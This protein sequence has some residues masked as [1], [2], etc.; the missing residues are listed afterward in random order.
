MRA[1]LMLLGL[2]ATANFTRCS[3]PQSFWCATNK[4]M[5]W[6]FQQRFGVIAF[7][8]SRSLGAAAGRR[9]RL[10]QASVTSFPLP[11][12]IEPSSMRD[13]MREANGWGLAPTSFALEQPLTPEQ[14]SRQ[15]CRRALTFAAPDIAAWELACTNTHN[16]LSRDT[17]AHSKTAGQ[18]WSSQ[19]H[20]CG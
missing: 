14:C 12:E 9:D 10:E 16:P 13:D 18:V 15:A 8:R 17:S 6:L 11:Y 7:F 4:L 2:G 5:T 19:R 1:G 3:Q 20:G